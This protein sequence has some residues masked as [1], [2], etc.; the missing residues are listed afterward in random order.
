MRYPII[1]ALSLVI[2]STA[3]RA[4]KGEPITERSVFSWSLIFVMLSL[5]GTS[6]LGGFSDMFAW[7]IVT[8]I[9]LNDGYQLL[10]DL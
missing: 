7:L 2:A 10:N 6:K 8:I 5:V 9:V 4:V 3:Y 1:I